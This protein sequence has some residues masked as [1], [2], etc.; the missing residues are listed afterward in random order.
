MSIRHITNFNEY[1]NVIRTLPCVIKFTAN[2]C[3]PC[4]R[5][6]PI[7]QGL[8]EKFSD[9]LTFIE[10]NI[11]NAKEITNYENVQSIPLILYYFN[12]IK[13]D[14]L[15]VNGFDP[16]SLIN[17]T[18]LLYDEINDILDT[19][20]TDKMTFE[21]ID[22]LSSDETDTSEDTQTSEDEISEKNE[23]DNQLD[24]TLEK[25]EPKDNQKDEKN[26]TED[27]IL[28]ITQSEILVTFREI[29]SRLDNLS[30]DYSDST[31]DDDHDY[32][33]DCEYIIESKN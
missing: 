30:L 15:T 1:K 31:T 18:V 27:K 17:N 20:N 10:I 3:G 6:A 14:S 11:S 2:W 23:T 13:D 16:Q 4:I 22:S 19:D 24:E 28:D 8:A 5:L 33:D 9:K 25:N 26:E 12:G 29:D 32:G 21:F 7:Y